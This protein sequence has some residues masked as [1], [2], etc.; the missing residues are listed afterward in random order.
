MKAEEDGEDGEE[1]SQDKTENLVEGLGIQ[2]IAIVWYWSSCCCRAP[3]IGWGSLRREEEGEQEEA[4][5]DGED[6]E[7]TSQDKPEKVVDDKM[8]EHHELD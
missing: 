5:E 8:E 7:E 6:G 4:E 2:D 3:H 1:T